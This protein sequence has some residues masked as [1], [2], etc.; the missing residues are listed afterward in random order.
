MGLTVVK[1][2]NDSIQPLEEKKK[3]RNP[4]LKTGGDV[5]RELSRLY[6]AGKQGERD[7]GDVSKLANVLSILGRLITGEGLEERIAELERSISK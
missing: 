1:K 5:R 7:I 3:T 4:P 2:T 6:F